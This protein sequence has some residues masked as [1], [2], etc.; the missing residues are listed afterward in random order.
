MEREKI[1]ISW[2]NANIDWDLSTVVKVGRHSAEPSYL[3]SP[4]NCLRAFRGPSVTNSW[5]NEIKSNQ[6]AFYRA[7]CNADAV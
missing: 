5:R 2:L 7:A 1:S 3:L 6:I 4:Q